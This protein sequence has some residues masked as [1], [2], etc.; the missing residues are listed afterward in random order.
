MHGNDFVFVGAHG[1]FTVA[2]QIVET[3]TAD[4]LVLTDSG[5]WTIVA[6]TGAYAVLHASGSVTGIANDHVDLITR[7]YQGKIHAS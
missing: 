4:P 3:L 1:T 2:V 7:F 5:S 6:G